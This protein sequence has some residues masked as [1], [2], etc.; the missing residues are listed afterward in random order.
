MGVDMCD[1]FLAVSLHLRVIVYERCLL[2]ILST[3][4]YADK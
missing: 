3:Y 4:H 1:N 2:Y